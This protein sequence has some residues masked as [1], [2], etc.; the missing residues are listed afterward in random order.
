[1]RDMVYKKKLK[2]G[3]DFDGVVAYNPFRIVRAPIAWWKRHVL[4]EKRLSFYYPTNALTKLMWTVLHDSSV[5]PAKGVGLLQTMVEEGIIDVHLITARY[6]FLDDHLDRW[7]RKHKLTTL[8]TSININ[9]RDEQPHIFKSRLVEQYKL[10]YYIEDNLDIVRHITQQL[11]IGTTHPT[12]IFWIYNVIDRAYPHPHKF[13][14]LQ[15]ALEEIM[16]I[17]KLDKLVK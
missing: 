7:L 16:R 11:P 2:V 8:F 4:G 10:D 5:F 14:Y 9:H 12:K 17:S 6:S 3:L 13:P 1:M 15:K